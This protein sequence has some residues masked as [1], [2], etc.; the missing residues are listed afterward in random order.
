M[1]K[2]YK[3][4]NRSQQ[5]SH[6][7]IPLMSEK[8]PIIEKSCQCYRAHNGTFPV[9]NT[10]AQLEVEA[11][12]TPTSTA[13]AGSAAVSTAVAAVAAAASE[14]GEAAAVAEAG[15]TPDGEAGAA[16]ASKR[17]LQSA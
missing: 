5:N 1:Q 13:V 16:R 9:L 4:Q 8:C 11:T 2:N 6:V 7:C 15:S 3:I 14:R 10:E 17:K 12:T